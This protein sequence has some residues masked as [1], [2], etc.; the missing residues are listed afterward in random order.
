ME[1][2]MKKITYATYI[3]ELRKKWGAL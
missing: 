1:E 3:C 2:E